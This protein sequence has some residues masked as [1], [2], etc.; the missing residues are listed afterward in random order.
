ML[1]QPVSN[2]SIR[3]SNQRALLEHWNALAAD[4]RFPSIAE[5]NP[6]ARDH[7][8]EQLIVWEVEGPM[9]FRAHRLGQRAAEVLGAGLV[10][11]TMDE[12]V[13]ASLRA[14]SLEGAD[15][16]ATS[17]CA[18][19]AII[20]TIANGHQVDCERLLLPFGDAGVVQQMIASLQLISFQGVIERQEVTRDFEIRSYVSLSGK[21][22]SDWGARNPVTVAAPALVPEL[23]PSPEPALAAQ[24]AGAQIEPAPEKA[25]V[26][27]KAARR[28]VLKTGKIH[29]GKKREVCTV[30]DISASGASLELARQVD[31]PDQF[32]LI[33]EMESASRRCIVVWRKERQLGIKFG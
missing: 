1:F 2:H 11:K 32:S 13:P 10:G 25:A 3:S 7:S 26:V 22:S 5:F 12:V 23:A 6:Q 8:P 30:R 21:I 9:R 17:G 14:V 28:K 27:R 19:Y 4:R 16:C 31:V 20:T 33:L 24:G 18:V 15:E 29:F